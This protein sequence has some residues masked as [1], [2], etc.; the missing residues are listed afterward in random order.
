MVHFRDF[1]RYMVKVL[2]GHPKDGRQKIKYHTTFC[3]QQQP[4]G[5][6]CGFYVCINMV[7]FGVHKHVHLFFFIVD[8][9]D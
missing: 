8:I 6:T 1:D 2:G 9:Y 5:N 4:L 3:V 7:T